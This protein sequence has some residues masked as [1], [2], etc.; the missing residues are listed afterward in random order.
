MNRS[1]AL[2]T[3]AALCLASTVA[4]GIATAAEVIDRKENF[5]FTVPE[6][7]ED[8]KGQFGLYVTADGIGSLVGG[9]LPFTPTSVEQAAERN[10]QL[11]ARANTTFRRI[12]TATPLKGKNW[13]A[14]VV[15]FEGNVNTILEMV[16]H[17]GRAYRTFA[18]T[19]RNEE[20]ARNKEKYWNILR[21]W[22]SPAI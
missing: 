12:G 18:L 4:S 20:Y 9:K 16:A 17:D 2:L 11:F 22:K 6:G 5:S 1:T 10:A 14:Q 8:Q 19:V 15:T 13:A 3:I 21:S 7:W